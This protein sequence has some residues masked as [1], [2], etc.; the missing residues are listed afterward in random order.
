MDV[1]REEVVQYTL[2]HT[3]PLGATGEAVL[4]AT[5]RDTPTPFLMSGLVESRLLEMLVVA[6]EA[7]TAL[8]IGTFTG[9]GALALAAAMGEGGRVTTVEYNGDLAG[10]ARANIEASPYADRIDL[11]VGDA[12][13]AIDRLPGPFDVVFLDAWKRDYVHYYE[14]VLPKLSPRGVIVADNVL[15]NGEVVDPSAG[16]EEA[17]AVVRFNDHVQADPRTTNTILSVA[18]GLLLAWRAPEPSAQA[19]GRPA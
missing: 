18:D 11:V 5:R 12:R 15:W 13:D 8:E 2:D 14:A 4:A 7:Q 17:Q 9:H 16:D 6:T 10:L 19:Y 3:T 1:V